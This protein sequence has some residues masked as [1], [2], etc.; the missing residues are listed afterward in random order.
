MRAIYAYVWAT[1]CELSV[2]QHE[3]DR[4]HRLSQSHLPPLLHRHLG[5]F[6]SKLKCCTV[7][8]AASPLFTEP[9]Y[10]DEGGCGG[11]SFLKL[12][13]HPASQYSLLAIGRSMLL[14]G[15]LGHLMAPTSSDLSHNES[16]Q[17]LVLSIR[18]SVSLQ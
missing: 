10:H 6:Y 9:T 15:L 5:C 18:L 16:N 8:L 17:E 11:K 7:H 2:F 12:R 3:R 14:L 13:I 1:V 4:L